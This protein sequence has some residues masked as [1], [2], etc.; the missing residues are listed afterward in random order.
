ME[1]LQGLTLGGW[2]FLILSWGA[3][4]LLAGYCFYRVYATG[5]YLSRGEESEKERHEGAGEQGSL[6]EPRP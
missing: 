2:L 6:S 5:P 4:L 3:M 1:D